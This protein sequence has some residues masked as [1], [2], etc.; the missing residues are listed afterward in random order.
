MQVDC[1]ESQKSLLEQKDDRNV[2]NCAWRYRQLIKNRDRE[3]KDSRHQL[4]IINDTL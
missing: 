2:G 3:L 1:R 4:S